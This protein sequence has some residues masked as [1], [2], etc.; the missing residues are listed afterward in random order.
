MCIKS[1]LYCINYELKI[2]KFPLKV[3]SVRGMNEPLLID[4][5]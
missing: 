3:R 5:K 2:I 1:F 4:A